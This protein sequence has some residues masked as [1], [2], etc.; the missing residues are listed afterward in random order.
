MNYVK[1]QKISKP[2]VKMNQ[3]KNSPYENPLPHQVKKKNVHSRLHA[4]YFLLP[5]SDDQ[6]SP[7]T[8]SSIHHIKQYAHTT[9]DHRSGLTWNFT[10]NGKILI[11][12]HTAFLLGTEALQLDHFRLSCISVQFAQF[13]FRALLLA[14]TIKRKFL[15][16]Y[17]SDRTKKLH[18]NGHWHFHVK[19]K[20]NKHFLENW[21]RTPKSFKC[22]CMS[23]LITTSFIRRA[24]F[25]LNVTFK[26]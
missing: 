4:K 18:V 22:Y 16:N 14:A 15:N 3:N 20:T 19:E 7:T 23:I 8:Y 13:A 25:W 26:I 6:C 5:W 2:S 17:K 9:F 11:F 1:Y 10:F 12:A 21:T 24:K